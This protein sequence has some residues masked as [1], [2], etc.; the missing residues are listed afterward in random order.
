MWPGAFN[1]FSMDNTIIFRQE[2]RGPSQLVEVDVT[3][4]GRQRVPFPDIAQLRSTTDMKIV[5][6]AMRFITADVLT[7]SMVSGNPTCPVTEAQKISLVIYCEGWE[8]AQF[9]PLLT[10]NDSSFAGSAYPHIYTQTNFSD[11]VNVSWDKCYLQY[12]NGTV[13]AGQP[14]TVL[15]DVQYERFNSRGE[16]IVGPSN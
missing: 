16:Y 15:L 5:I 3:V 12:A 9:L 14:Y 1:N 7:N 13:S 2:P 11:W 8:K 6:K 10:L 4:D